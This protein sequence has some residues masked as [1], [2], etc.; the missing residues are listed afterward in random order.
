MNYTGNPVNNVNASSTFAEST[1]MLTDLMI[2][3]GGMYSCEINSAAIV[4]ARTSDI[5]ITVIGGKIYIIIE[6][7]NGKISER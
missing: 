3:D 5:S 4:M 1:I 2:S 6:Y 7:Y